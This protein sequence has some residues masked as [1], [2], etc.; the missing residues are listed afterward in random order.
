MSRARIQITALNA[1]A[2]IN[3]LY[4]MSISNFIIYSRYFRMKKQ[5]IIAYSTLLIPLYF[6]LSWIFVWVAYENLTQAD[7][8][9]EFDKLIFFNP[10]KSFYWSQFII[11]LLS[12][13]SLIFFG[14][15]L[16]NSKK[17]LPKSINLMFT[18]LTSFIVLITIWGML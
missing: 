11:L 6:Y 8:V 18:M 5:R 9:V 15:L 16:A 2:V 1:Y 3:R 12:I 4:S 17:I 10:I 13:V 7:K 14:R